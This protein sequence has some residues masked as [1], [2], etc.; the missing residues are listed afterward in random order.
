MSS[1]TRMGGPERRAL[2]QHDNAVVHV[3]AVD[4]MRYFRG[5]VTLIVVPAMHTVDQ[6]TNG[7]EKVRI[8]I[9]P[10]AQSGQ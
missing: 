8:R 6:A 9:V 4:L 3:D 1:D 5:F 10:P 7:V 2:F